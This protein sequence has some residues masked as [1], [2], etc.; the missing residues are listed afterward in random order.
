M[1]V[2]AEDFWDGLYAGRRARSLDAGPNAML[3]AVLSGLAQDLRVGY[4]LDL[5]C[6]EGSDSVWLADRGWDVLGVDVSP[7]ALERTR[8]RAEYAGVAERVRT[9]Q[10]DLGSS[11]P[12][13][14]FDLVA[15]SYLQTPL[16]FPRARI[17]QQAA[18]AVRPGGLLLIVDHA[19][20]APWSWDRGKDVV[21]P[22]PRETLDTLE[23]DPAD[24][25][26]HR[27]EAARREAAAPDGRVA[28]VTDNVISLRRN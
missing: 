18:A 12:S 2:T 3:V 24:W 6:A 20:T 27:V 26:E 7:T 13:G 16:S 19:S 1:D 17:L 25:T 9:E 4:A 8:A 22:T 11:F 14:R 5:G 23:L 21:Y 10:H 15:A 28:T